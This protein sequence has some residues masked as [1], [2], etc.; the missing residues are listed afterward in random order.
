MNNGF[1]FCPYLGFLVVL[2]C[3]FKD[4]RQYKLATLTVF[5][6]LYLILM[7]LF[8]RAHYS[9]DIFGGLV[10]GHYFWIMGERV[11]VLID[12]YLMNIP[13]HKRF[14]NFEKECFRCKNPINEWINVTFEASTDNKVDDNI[15][16]HEEK[17]FTYSEIQV[18]NSASKYPQ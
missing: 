5:A 6:M 18:Q 10:F 9:I 4:N 13:F 16:E 11:S 17:E 8:T 2:F 14:P 12:F 3:E 1:Y 15:E 7:L